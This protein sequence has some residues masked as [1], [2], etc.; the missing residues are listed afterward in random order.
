MSVQ[1]IYSERTD[2]VTDEQQE[3]ERLARLM[4]MESAHRVVTRYAQSLNWSTEDT[5][6]ILQTLGLEESPPPLKAVSRR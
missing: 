3:K 4:E 1:P 5:E 6:T 2:A